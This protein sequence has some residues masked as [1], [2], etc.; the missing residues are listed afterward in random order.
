VNRPRLVLADDHVM[1]ME[2]L[3][4]ILELHF[5]VVGT[6]EDGE[7]AV[8]AVQQLRPDVV[9]MDI[10]MPLL[11]GIKTARK[12]RQMG[13]SSK[14]V[15]LTM[16]AD[17]AFVAEA[18]DAGACGYVL[19]TAAGSEIVAAIREAMDGRTYVSPRIRPH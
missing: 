18:F 16:F 11:N 6:Y 17:P 13:A 5:D 7:K 4:N 10:S 15:F 19:K 9:V 2:G 3:R 14:I 12:L 8:A 1:F